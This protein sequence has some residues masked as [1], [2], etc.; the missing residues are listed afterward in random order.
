VRGVQWKKRQ[1][2]TIIDSSEDVRTIA[3]RTKLAD[4]EVYLRNEADEVVQD[5]RFLVIH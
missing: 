3:S 1:Q 2:V 5:D 4:T